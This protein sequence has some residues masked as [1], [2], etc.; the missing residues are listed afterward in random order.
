G[1]MFRPGAERLAEHAEI[2][3]ARAKVGGQRKA[4]RAG[5]N[6]GDIANVFHASSPRRSR[7]ETCVSKK[8]RIP[9]LGGTTRLLSN[10]VPGTVPA[11]GLLQ[12]KGR[13][14]MSCKIL[15]STTVSWV[16]TARHAAGFAQAGCRV[17]AIAPAN[18]PVRLSRYISACHPYRSVSGPKS[19]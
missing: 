9:V 7:F 4:V 16:S 12:A 15:I 6:D 14:G 18:A 17:E 11:K 13:R 2:D 19:L 3:S 8:A 10:P 5:A 1:H